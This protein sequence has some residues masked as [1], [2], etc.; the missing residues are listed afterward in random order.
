MPSWAFEGGGLL[1]NN[2]GG[3]FMLS[4]GP[5]L[6]TQTMMNAMGSANVGQGGQDYWTAGALG[7]GTAVIGRSGVDASGFLGV[8]FG[9]SESGNLGVTKASA[10]YS[11]TSEF[12]DFQKPGGGR[13]SP[14]VGSE[15]DADVIPFFIRGGPDAL[16]AKDLHTVDVSAFVVTIKVFTGPDLNEFRGVAGIF[17]PGV[18]FSIIRGG[19]DPIFVRDSPLE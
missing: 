4:D 2:F 5:T 3:P 6:Q 14:I 12:G 8:T 17:G 15:F 11:F 1:A 13:T 10:G 18:G 16:F 19:F 7:G 9:R